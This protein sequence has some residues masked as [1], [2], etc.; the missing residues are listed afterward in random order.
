ML[1][2]VLRTSPVRKIPATGSS[3]D[4]LSGAALSEAVRNTVRYV[5]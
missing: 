2:F 1:R 4:R 5:P 3:A